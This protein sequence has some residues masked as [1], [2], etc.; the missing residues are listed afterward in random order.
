MKNI[1]VFGLCSSMLMILASAA[2][3]G[4]AGLIM[5][6]IQLGQNVVDGTIPLPYVLGFGALIV[7]IVVLGASE[8]RKNARKA[9]EE[10]MQ[11]PGVRLDK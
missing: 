11:N 10:A 7:A 3:A 1:I 2:H 5:D 6:L 4:P 8:A 9:A